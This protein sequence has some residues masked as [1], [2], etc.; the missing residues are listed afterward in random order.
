MAHCKGVVT[1]KGKCS[2]TLRRMEGMSDQLW[3]MTYTL[4]SDQEP[5]VMELDESIRRSRDDDTIMDESPVED[6]RCNGCIERAT[7]AAQDPIR[8]MK[9]Y[10]KD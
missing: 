4:K 1:N 10:W 5:A 9:V 6:S 3:H 7:Q 8:T 2:H